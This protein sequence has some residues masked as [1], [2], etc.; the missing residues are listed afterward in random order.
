[1]VVKF[2]ATLISKFLL[3]L[4]HGSGFALSLFKEI[5]MGLETLLLIILLLLFI[6]ALPSWPYSRGWGYRPSGG[7]GV[8]ALI[9]VVFVLVGRGGY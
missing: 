4:K 8:L 7:L 1:M 9:V 5:N 2:L 6:G 3:Y